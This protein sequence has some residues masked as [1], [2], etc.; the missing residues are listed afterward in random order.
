LKWGGQRVFT[1]NYAWVQ[2][3]DDKCEYFKKNIKALNPIDFNDDNKFMY[4]AMQLPNRF[5]TICFDWAT[6]KFFT[7]E[8]TESLYSR[9]MSLK[10][11]LKEDG[12]IYFE[13]GLHGYSQIK[14]V[15]GNI[16][17]TYKPERIPPKIDKGVFTSICNTIG[18][19]VTE[20]TMQFTDDPV[21]Q[22]VYGKRTEPSL[23]SE[24][25]FLV[26]SKTPLRGGR[27]TKRQTKRR[28]RRRASR[29]RI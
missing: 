23:G 29:K 7:G 4:L 9:I 15:P 14:M 20:K 10:N 5:Q 24:Q 17:G 3:I 6:M 16:P 12:R 27:R 25:I 13:G 8:S 28:Y 1:H 21:L 19:H 11:L 2:K 22:E 18:L 26:V